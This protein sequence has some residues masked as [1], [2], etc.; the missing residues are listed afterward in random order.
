MLVCNARD[1][2]EP[3]DAL[4]STRCRSSKPRS[5]SGPLF[6]SSALR[7]CE[8]ER[9]HPLTR[10]WPSHLQTVDQGLAQLHMLAITVL[11]F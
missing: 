2:L 10:A 8:A 3:K 6:P 5:D 11:T 4:C 1:L 7:Q 9:H